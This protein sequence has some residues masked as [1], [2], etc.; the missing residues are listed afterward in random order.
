M[1]LDE[2]IKVLYE[3]PLMA[4]SPN[5]GAS[6]WAVVRFEYPRKRVFYRGGIRFKGIAA[7]RERNEHCI[8][9]LNHESFHKLIEIENSEWAKEIRADIHEGWSD[10]G[11]QTH[12]YM[13]FVDDDAAVE[14]V[15]DSWDLLPEEKGAWPKISIRTG[16]DG[17]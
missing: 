13:I 17:P 15:A 11:W 6:F 9:P 2:K 1:S 12:H 7:K 3:L 14:V 4:T 10:L 8:T 5:D 16:I